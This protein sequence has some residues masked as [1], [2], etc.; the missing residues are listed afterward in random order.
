MGAI[1]FLFTVLTSAVSIYEFLCLIYILMSWFPGARYT[2][3]GNVMAQICEPF[4][5]FFRRF[6]IRIGM[7]DFSP[8]L[9]FGALA[10]LSS[11]FGDIAS[12]GILRLGVLLAS[13]IQIC[14]SLLSSVITFFNIILVIRLVVHLAGK[15]FT[16]QIWRT[17]D[18]IISPVQTRISSLIFKNKFRTYRAQLAITLGVC[19]IVQIAGSWI[20]GFLATLLVKIPF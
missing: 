13:L 12:Y 11:I 16:S 10:L 17:L 7:I 19:V 20:I 9:A 2:K 14:W 8:I 5:S 6:P 4:L 1:K 18:Q 3:F 15:D